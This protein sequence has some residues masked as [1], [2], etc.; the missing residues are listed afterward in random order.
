[1]GQWVKVRG[2]QRDDGMSSLSG[3]RMVEE[4]EPTLVCC[5]MT[6]TCTLWHTHE[7]A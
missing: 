4:E 1:M 6:S 7:S 5:P 3:T 2:T